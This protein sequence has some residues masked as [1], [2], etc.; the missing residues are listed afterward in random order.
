[1]TIV[2]P[3]AGLSSRFTQAGFTLPKY[4]LYLK[5]Y[6]M[7]YLSM[8]GFRA[9][10]DV[11]EFLFITRGIYDSKRFI[12]SE[13]ALLGIKKFKI[14]E[15]DSVTSGQAETV[16][17]GLTRAQVDKEEELLIHN[18]D[19]FKKSYSLPEKISEM[20]G[21]LEVFRGEGDNWSYARTVNMESSRVI[22]TAEKKQISNYCSTGLYYF[23]EVALFQDAYRRVDNKLTAETYVAPIYN[24]LI[25]QE[26]AIHIDVIDRE[27]VVFC[28]VPEEYYE[29]LALRVR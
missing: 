6:S 19:T 16:D 28:G 17:L 8:A 24:H 9:F 12:E 25:N 1:M 26:Y 10:F 5:N 13:C 4:M 29:Q 11:F 14:V 23:R 22:E 27:D 21:Y 15:L 3:M 2:I 18:I 20:D 7:F